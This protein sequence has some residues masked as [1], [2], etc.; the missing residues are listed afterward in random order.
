MHLGYHIIGGGGDDGASQYISSIF[1]ALPAFPQ[2][3][4]CERTARFTCRRIVFLEVEEI[5]D[6]PILLFVKPPF[7]ETIGQDQA[8]LFAISSAKGRFLFQCIRAGVDQAV[9]DIGDAG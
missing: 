1:T 9:A 5:R 6:F 4:K 3:S 7:V 8:A 2:S